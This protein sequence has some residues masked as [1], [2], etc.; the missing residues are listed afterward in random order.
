MKFICEK[1]MP[2]DGSMI[3]PGIY[4]VELDEELGCF[5]VK[6]AQGH[7]ESVNLLA[8]KDELLECGY[9]DTWG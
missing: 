1:Q 3:Y 4:K 2:L 8:Y 6:K 9:L 7:N 5:I